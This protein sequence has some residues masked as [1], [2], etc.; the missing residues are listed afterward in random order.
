MVAKNKSEKYIKLAVYLVVVVL[1]N[2]AGTTL[3][4]RWDMTKNGVYSLS[5]VSKEVVANLTEPLTIKAFFS[6]DLPAPYNGTERYLRDLLEEYAVH[7]NRFFNYQFYDVSPQSDGITSASNENQQMASNYGIQPLQIQQLENDEFK[8]RLAYMGI[9]VIQGDIVERIPAITTTDGLEY[10]LTTTLQKASKKI[11][12]LVGLTENIDVKLILSPSLEAVSPLIGL[13]E[14]PVLPE[15]VQTAVENLNRKNYNRLSFAFLDP[16]TDDEQTAV[17]DAYDVL[18][19]KWD[20]IEEEDIPAGTGVVGL[21]MSL[22]DKTVSLPILQVY[23][24]P[25]FGTQYDLSTPKE[26]EDMI[27]GQVETLVNVNENIGYLADHGTLSLA[28]NAAAMM[29][30]DTGGDLTVFNTLLGSSYSI[31]QFNLTE[32]LVPADVRCLI[33]ARPTE[34][35]TDW[36]LFQLDQALMRGQNLAIF[37]DPF[38]EVVSQDM[39]YMGQSQQVSYEPLDTGL[40]KLLAHWGIHVGQ[41]IVMD[42][43][44]YTQASNQVLGG[45]KQSI[46]YAPIV[47]PENIDQ[48]LPMMR[49]IK[50]FLALKVSP[51]T[52]DEETLKDNNLT[53]TVAFSSSERAWEMESP[54]NLNPMYHNPPASDDLFEK[55]PLAVLIK[56]PFPS[57]F[58]GKAVPEKEAPATESNEET[59]ITEE[60]EAPKMPV[61][62]SEGGII[63]T[64]A[65]ARVFLIGSGDMLQDSLLDEN[66]I[67]TNSMLLMNMVDMLNGHE[68]TALMRSKTQSHNPLNSTSALVKTTVKAV[69]IAGLPILVVVFGMLVWM[70]R[71]VRRKTIQR[72][73]ETDQGAV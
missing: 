25:I 3:F 6:R 14:L 9:V 24:V 41:S 48:S 31:R 18:P 68:D 20:Y 7:G 57:Y 10:T 37:L 16:V 23:R 45:G 11:S 58:N 38:K 40:E 46:Y 4:L 73:F 65:P 55:K 2:L 22:G 13:A 28:D 66:G 59:D 53:A 64:G 56:G 70:R 21:A 1:I 12:S 54:I 72:M 36:E 35:F 34:P 30:L 49:N 5:D 15:T 61:V 32:D 8:S 51:L 63:E 52:L 69:N 17:I 33:I 67:S 44:C 43:A 27:D 71:H 19:L 39:A 62:T 26:I 47:Q 42:E 29:G 50:E 60:A